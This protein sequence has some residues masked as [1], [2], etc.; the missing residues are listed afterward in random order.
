VRR[1]RVGGWDCTLER[2]RLYVDAAKVS[3]LGRLGP[4]QYLVSGEVIRMPRPALQ[5]TD[6]RR[7]TTEDG[8]WRLLA[9]ELR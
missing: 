7:Q 6:D 4:D 3:P 9:A 5:T 2:G 1:R 8:C